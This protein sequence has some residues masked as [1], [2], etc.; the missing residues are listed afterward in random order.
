M[1][2]SFQERDSNSQKKI[3]SDA[4][5]SSDWAVVLPDITHYFRVI[6]GLRVNRDIR[7]SFQSVVLQIEPMSWRGT[8]A[9]CAVTVY[10]NIWTEVSA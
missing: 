8:L 5:V 7:V 2:T 4:S 10:T 3:A 6:S 9:G 1:R